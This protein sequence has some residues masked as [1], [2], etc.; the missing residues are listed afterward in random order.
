[1]KKP[2]FYRYVAVFAY[3]KDGVHVTFPDLPGCVTFGITEAEAVQ[4]AKIA[5]AL[6]M[7]GMEED[8]EMPPTP[9]SA[10]EIFQAEPREDL[11]TK[12]LLLVE[13]FMP[14]F[15]DEMRNHFVKKT[16]SIPA[17]LNAEAEAK[18]VNFSHLLQES[19]K[20]YLGVQSSESMTSKA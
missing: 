6:H 20:H 3:E 2:N 4:E 14:S 13:A 10:R 7:W 18:G 16:L 8:Q 5:L 19:L 15:R 1:M 17:W 12:T 11:E 9:S